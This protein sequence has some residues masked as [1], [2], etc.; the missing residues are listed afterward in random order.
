MRRSASAATVEARDVVLVLSVCLLLWEARRAAVQA[1]AADPAGA[2]ARSSSSFLQTPGLFMR[3][4]RLHA[5]R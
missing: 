2:L 1:V 4:A 5:R 3:H